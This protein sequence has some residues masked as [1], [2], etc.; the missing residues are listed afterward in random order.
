MNPAGRRRSI[1]LIGGVIVLVLAMLV[2]AVVFGTI[3]RVRVPDLRGMT[4]ATITART[5]H[6][7]LHFEFAS[8][9]SDAPRGTAIQQKPAA[10]TRAR[11]G[12]A[13][14]VVLSAG[15]A[16]VPTPTLVGMPADQAEAALHRLRLGAS[17]RDVPAPGVATGVVTNQSPA[18]GAKLLPG[19]T[20]LLSVAEAPRWR[21]LTTFSGRSSVPFRIRGRRWRVV[22][23]MGY[24]GMCTFIFICSGPSA[25]TVN[26]GNG[27]T[28]GSFDLNE[29]SGQAWTSST[30][31]GV[32]QVRITPGSDTASWSVEVDDY[33]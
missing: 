8:Q 7:S 9:Y 23:R 5:R 12:S 18:T 10:G 26:I 22:Y 27:S 32:Y 30:G 29:G 17:V 28:A 19:S 15:P 4:R 25:R 14:R 21:A 33:Y 2:A 24:D 31:P 13:V 1:A 20:V 3:G 16:P 6:V 11:E